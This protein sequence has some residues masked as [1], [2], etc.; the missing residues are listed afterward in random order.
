MN[1]DDLCFELSL[2]WRD[3]VTLGEIDLAE[4][5]LRQVKLLRRD[6]SQPVV[7]ASLSLYR[8]AQ[9][10]IAQRCAKM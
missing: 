8:D 1:T 7:D 4:R 10:I 3:A 6:E 9:Q 2:T 5:V